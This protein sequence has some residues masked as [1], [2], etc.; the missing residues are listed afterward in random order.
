VAAAGLP[1]VVDASVGAAWLFPDEA[2]PETEAA[3]HATASVDVW[4]PAL[5]PLEIGNLVLTAQ[6]RRRITGDKR[7]ELVRAA[8]SLRLRIDRERTDMVG[9]D[10]LA[11]AHG[12][13]TYDAVYLEL[14]KRR[15]LALA[16]RDEKLMAA[17][18]SAGV[19]PAA[20]P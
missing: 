7:R 9:L 13:T 16:T 5:W 6:R 8:A 11:A 3:L 17:L 14:A 10:E 18:A 15:G 20:F 12:L 2:T 4:V 19:A 1:F